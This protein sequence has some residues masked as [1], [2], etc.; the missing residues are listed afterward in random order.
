MRFKSYVTTTEG[1]KQKSPCGKQ[2]RN[3]IRKLQQIMSAGPTVAKVKQCSSGIK[4][5]Q[6]DVRLALLL[7]IQGKNM[8][9]L[10]KSGQH[11]T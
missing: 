9:I 4:A 7:Q 11:L 1:V 8:L 5:V 10:F 2:K 6:F 3:T